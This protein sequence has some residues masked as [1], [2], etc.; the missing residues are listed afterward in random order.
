MDPTRAPLV[1]P[2][3]TTRIRGWGGMSVR[4][5]ELR[6]PDLARLTEGAVLS[7]GLGRA[8]GDAALTPAGCTRP[9]AI[10]TSADRILGFDPQTGRLRAE[11]GLS[12]SELARI[13]L[14]RGWFTPISPGTQHV[15]LGG[16]VA[17]DIH[18]KNHHGAGCFGDHVL[19]MQMLLGSGDVVTCSRQENE[20]LFWATIGGMGL[21]GLILTATFALYPIQGPGMDLETVR[22][23]NLDHFFEVSAA[24]KDFTH[25]VT[26][27]DTVKSGRGLGRGVFQRARHANADAVLEA[28]SVD[29]MAKAIGKLVDG[30]SFDSNHLLNRFTVRAFNEAYFRKE[31]KGT[32]RSV[33]PYKPFFFPLDSVPNWNYIYGPRGFLQYQLV[34]PERDAVRAALELVSSSGQASF[35]SV[36]KEFGDLDH[37]GISFPQRG[38]TLAMDFPNTGAPLLRLFDDLDALVLEA[39]GRVYL[40]K[41]ARLPRAAFE[42][43]YPERERWQ[44]VRDRYDPD[45]VFTSD[46]AR[47]LRL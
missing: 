22:I 29:R 19:E 31:K 6:G 10:S 4:G 7:R 21:T 38:I 2:H 25:V 1:F 30:K 5:V 11:A 24:S 17:S 9:V 28:G 23:E 27:I 41:D 36:I 12:L 42:R 20:D 47:R 16:M 33:S 34:V 44:N 39:R 13:Y 14:P 26:W 15:T 40:G 37:G 3:G 35:L 46:L 32:A 45:R 43:M 8:Y 18:G